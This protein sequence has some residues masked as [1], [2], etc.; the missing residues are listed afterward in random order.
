M[1]QFLCGALKHCVEQ[2]GAPYPEVA[3]LVQCSAGAGPV[4]AACVALL[5]LQPAAAFHFTPAHPATLYYDVR[6][7]LPQKETS[8]TVL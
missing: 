3:G 7:D 8:F 5:L 6:Y 1:T 2:C 4:M